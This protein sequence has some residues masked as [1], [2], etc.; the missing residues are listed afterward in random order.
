MALRTLAKNHFLFD[1]TWQH[2]DTVHIGL[3]K[4]VWF[5]FQNIEKEFSFEVKRLTEYWRRLRTT[6]R[7]TSSS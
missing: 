2:I 7:V 5:S 6:E 1:Q 4:S 3:K